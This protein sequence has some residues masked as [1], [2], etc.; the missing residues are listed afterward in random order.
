M[1]SAVSEG[2]VE[3]AAAAMLTGGAAAGAGAYREEELGMASLTCGIG[4]G[5]GLD[6]FFPKGKFYV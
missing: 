6:L 5:H 1:T 2:A 3:P 4:Q